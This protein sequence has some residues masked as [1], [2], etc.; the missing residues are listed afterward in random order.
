MPLVAL[1]VLLGL[2]V[3][4]ATQSCAGG[5]T[6]SGTGNSSGS[7]NTTGT[8]NRSGSGGN[9]GFTSGGSTGFTSGG[10]TGINS[11][12]N[13]GF[14]SGGN[15]GFTTGGNTGIPTG[16]NTGQGTGGMPVTGGAL[17]VSGGF[18]TNGTWM[19]YAYT[20]TFPA[21]GSVAT[22]A[23]MC[24]TPCFPS[25]N[26]QL[27]ANG[28]VGAQ[29]TTPGASGAILGW[30]IGQAMATT[31]A[32]PPVTN[33]VPTGTGLKLTLS[34]AVPGG[35]IQIQDTNNNQWC[36]Q[37]NPSGSPLPT[38]NMVP[39]AMFNTRC[40]SPLDPAAA[41]YNM[42]PIAAVQVVVPSAATTTSFNF[43]IT[44]ARSY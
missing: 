10:N 41:A 34:A 5:E 18:A 31:T 19:G 17:T 7:G 42:A 32:S 23:P 40:Y 25:T 16:G 35:R 2:P 22:V 43:C 39:W 28:M 11:G 8:G 24:P 33:V 9:T 21:T 3:L 44:D 37:V 14:N 26:T 1:F 27:C 6:A 30:S 38:T 36:F 12:G 20:A 13:T 4:F 15:T 29:P